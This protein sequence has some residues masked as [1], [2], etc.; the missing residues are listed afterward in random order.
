MSTSNPVTE[1][2][3]QHHHPMHRSSPP[4][5]TP[6]PMPSPTF[7]RLCYRL[8]LYPTPLHPGFYCTFR[9]SILQVLLRDNV[10]LGTLSRLPSPHPPLASSFL[11]LSITAPDASL[12]PHAPFLRPFDRLLPKLSASAPALLLQANAT[13][14]DPYD[15]L[16]QFLAMLH[17]EAS[18]AA[19]DDDLFGYQF[20]TQV[21]YTCVECGETMDT[22]PP[23][24][25][26]R[27]VFPM[28][29]ILRRGEDA[30]G[31]GAAPRMYS[32]LA[33]SLRK[34]ELPMPAHGYV[35][36]CGCRSSV[37]TGRVTHA[38]R[39][40][41]VRVGRLDSRGGVWGDG[42]PVDVEVRMDVGCLIGA[43]RGSRVYELG[44][45]VWMKGEGAWGEFG[46]DIKVADEW[47]RCEGERV[48]RLDGE[49]RWGERAY[50]CF[51]W[52]KDD[53]SGGTGGA[54][55]GMDVQG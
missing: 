18:S 47:V 22:T 53:A 49:R 13:P 4:Y 42:A 27:T 41:V 9:T 54:V 2:F 12:L 8:P 34:F 44:A 36:E 11:R 17:R 23:A 20:R 48:F 51:Y 5:P 10:L 35:D 15:F 30:Q 29:E 45:V 19:V 1:A 25:V 24:R 38:P 33:D 40:L 21:S 26:G 32:L 7:L 55:V 50:L 14:P 52:R 16:A 43:G 28:P 46:A 37:V 39:V 31:G 6:I 3:T